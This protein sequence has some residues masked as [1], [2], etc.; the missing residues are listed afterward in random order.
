M[1][2][3]TASNFA[4]Q[5]P[6]LTASE[7]LEAESTGAGYA[8]MLPVLTATYDDDSTVVDEIVL[9]WNKYKVATPKNN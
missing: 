1:V 8:G 2:L 7:N 5:P 4:M 6:G 9:N 3:R